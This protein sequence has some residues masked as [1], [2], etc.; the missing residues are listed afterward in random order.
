MSAVPIRRLAD[1]FTPA[2][3]ACYYS[4]RAPQIRQI[5]REWRGPCPFHNGVRDSF[6]INPETG[7]W[8]CH[9]ECRCG[10]SLLD[11]ECRHSGKPFAEAACEVRAILGHD[12]Q[13]RPARRIVATYSYT[14]ENDVTLF[15]C[16][17]YEPKAFSQ[18]RPDGFGGWIPNLQGVRRVLFHLP[19]LQA[20]DTVLIVEGEKDVLNLE[21]LGFVATC[22]SMGAGKWR[23]EYSDQLAGKNAVILP[24][25]DESG[26]NHLADVGASLTGKATSVRVLRVPVGKDVSDWIAVGATRELILEAIA[27][28][29]QFSEGNEP[30]AANDH[31]WRKE[32]MTTDRGMPKAVLANAIT[33]LRLAPKWQ[34]VLAFDEF[35]HATVAV[36]P[37]PWGSTTVEW[38]DQEDRLTANWLQHEGIFV[39]VEIAGQAVQAA[40]RD[41]RVHPVREYLDKLD[42]DGTRRLDSW[43]S[44]Y[45]GVERSDYSDAV[46]ARWMISG[47]ARVYEPGVKA[48]CCLILE[49]DQGIKK[50]TALRVLTGDWFTDEIAELGSKDAALQTRGVW[51]IEI[52]ELDSMSRAEVG[53]IKAFMSRAVD[54]Y[55]PPYGKRLVESP[56]QCIFAGSVNHTNYLRDETGARRFWPVSCGEIKIDDLKR[57]RDQLWAEARERYKS[58]SS[59]WLDS[60]AL[61]ACAEEEQS[62]RCEQDPWHDLIVQWLVDREDASIPEILTACIDKPKPHWNQQD[63]N[64][65]A[66][67]LRA[68]GWKRRRVGG[69]G[70]RE[71]RYKKS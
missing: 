10:G 45:L 52:A 42:W 8:F 3:I 36:A 20:A 40:A 48:D 30:A 28:A 62:E 51:I 24:D 54:R 39:S 61:N 68:L 49:G 41:H 16:V 53:K 12:E 14:D 19:Q 56:R 15:Q 1:R 2:E 70:D 7:E 6:A 47:V 63:Q 64:R 21:R 67:V 58:G 43:L 66:R 55:R 26:E 60:R 5:G 33:A 35:S 9:S 65:V 44:S 11:F 37:L 59:W 25:N 57:D 71:W 22:N 31:D 32:L 69:R 17:R 29:T 50:S 34:G 27:A 23:P 38:T 13:R 46:G 4:V 18:R